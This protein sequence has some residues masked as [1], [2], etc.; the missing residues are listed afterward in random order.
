MAKLIIGVNDLKS[1][2]PIAARDWNYERNG[3]LRPEDVTVKSNKKVWWK[4]QKGHEFQMIISN[5]TRTPDCCPI[6]SGKKLISGINDF[7]T[8]YPDLLKQW[9]YSRNTIDPTKIRPHKTDNVW[10]ICEFGHSWQA[11]VS[12]RVS[13]RGCPICKS[14]T[15][16]SFPEQA[17]FYYFKQLFS[18]A[19]N[20]YI[21]DNE[22][23]DVFIP[24]LNLGI[25]YDG[26]YYHKNKNDKDK[27]KELILKK[28]GITLIRVKEIKK[29]LVDDTSNPNY[30]KQN[31][32]IYIYASTH[33]ELDSL[34]YK[35]IEYIVNIFKLNVVVPSINV[36]RDRNKIY[37]LY[38]K[39]VKE[40]SLN[41][42]FPH[43]VKEWNYD[44]NN[45]IK[46]DM[47]TPY[48]NKIV[49]WKCDKGHEWEARISDRTLHKRGCPYCTNQRILKG[50]NDLYTINPDLSSEW[51]YEKNGKLTPS[52]VGAG[53]TKK[54]W[55]KCK[56]NHEWKATVHDR[57]LGNE[58]PYCSGKI[59]DPTKTSLKAKYP[60]LANEWHPTKNGTVKPENVMPGT[61]KKYW[62]LCSVCGYEW[63]ESPNNRRRSKKGC[64][65]C[66]QQKGMVGVRRKVI[67]L[68][69][70]EIYD[71]LTSA[72]KITMINKTSIYNCCR[73]KTKTAG[74]FRWAYVNNE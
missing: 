48:S 15:Q 19:I 36:S 65:K 27:Q 28:L 10:W 63:L 8:M 20:R 24:S 55:W 52:D 11:S 45:L 51:D 72:S 68:D 6:C 50:Y 62:W 33:K 31:E 54:V 42:L 22:E 60:N 9:D 18:D 34:I 1:Q 64:P 29:Y 74:G 4:C 57:Q 47:L 30:Y 21:V 39:S 46:P 73:G 44:K 43:I 17:I 25:E 58:C 71:S 67:N 69:T 56:N 32:F 5:K 13:G 16:T 12:S 40:N 61:L 38:V 41:N 26:Y 53:S 23:I 35:I 2:S 59:A 37:S 70:K 49:W 7:A 66:A 3:D 14:E